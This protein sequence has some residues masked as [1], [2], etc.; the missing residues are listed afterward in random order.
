MRRKSDLLVSEAINR[1]RG[2]TKL[3]LTALKIIPRD[4]K[5]RQNQYALVSGLIWNRKKIIQ[6][7]NHDEG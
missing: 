7:F 1:Q 3:L 2:M 4:G 6:S 5:T